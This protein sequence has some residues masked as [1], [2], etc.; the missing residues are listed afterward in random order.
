MYLDVGT[1]KSSCNSSMI[2]GYYRH[3]ILDEKW[4]H[5]QLTDENKNELEEYMNYEGQLQKHISRCIALE[6]P[7]HKIE[8]TFSDSSLKSKKTANIVTMES[9]KNLLIDVPSQKT[10]ATNLNTKFSVNNFNPPKSSSLF[11]DSQQSSKKSIKSYSEN[12]SQMKGEMNVAHNEDSEADKIKFIKRMANFRSYSELKPEKNSGINSDNDKNLNMNSQKPN[13]HS[14]KRPPSELRKLQLY[15]L[16][17]KFIYK[18]ECQSILQIMQMFY[19]FE[20]IK[21]FRKSLL[22]SYNKA[23]SLMT[24]FD[25]YQLQKLFEYTIFYFYTTNE[26]I[27]DK[28][29]CFDLDDLVNTIYLNSQKIDNESYLN[30]NIILNAEKQYNLLIG[31]M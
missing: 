13:E 19:L 22:F 26:S 23:N 25:L 29:I 14:N 30:I 27:K 6:C 24:K 10:L 2:Y 7:C 8:S 15:M 31:N 20:N 11:A 21:K 1:D 12:Y 4:Y 9:E 28:K 18:N 3:Q 16:N 17:Q 5:N